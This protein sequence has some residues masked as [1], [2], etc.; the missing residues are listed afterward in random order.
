M[1]VFDCKISTMVIKNKHNV[2]K[3]MLTGDVWIVWW[4]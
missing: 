4:C 3:N 2:H 1:S